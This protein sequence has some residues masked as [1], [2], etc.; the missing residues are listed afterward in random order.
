MNRPANLNLEIL[1][2]A[3]NHL[4]PL[5][6]DMVFLGGCATGLLLTDP[7][8]PPIR[9]TI[10]VD[11]IVG[12]G[13]L[14]EYYALSDQ[15]RARGFREDTSEDAPLC[16]W[17]AEDVILDVMP[18]DEK[19]LGFSNQWYTPAMQQAGEV[20]LSTGQKIKMVT[21][22]YFL[23]TK[24]EA[25]YGRGGGDYLS[26]HDMEDLLAVIDGRPGIVEEIASCDIDL[27]SYLAKQF[28]QLVNDK[29]FIE[30][31]PGHLPGDPASQ[32]RVPIIMDR[33]DLI[34]GKAA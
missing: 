9:A 30:A 6:D 20:E 18:I 5:V 22:P 28:S 11:V 25:F 7:A 29:S 14:S 33:I 8:A 13:S 31:I 16:R 32:A 21:A 3:V 12:V 15:L 26:S 4:G 34:Q 27:R 23:A 19:I 17:V 10:D 24:M 2:Q 1:L